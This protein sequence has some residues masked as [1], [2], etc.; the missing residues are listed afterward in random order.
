MDMDDN[1]RA[2]LRHKF[3]QVEDY[4]KHIAR[5]LRSFEKN[6]ELDRIMQ[7]TRAILRNIRSVY[8]HVKRLKLF[9][10]ERIA[11]KRAKLACQNKSPLETL[12]MICDQTMNS[13][14]IFDT[15]A[16]GTRFALPLFNHIT[17]M[18]MTEVGVCALLAIECNKIELNGKASQSYID[19]D[20]ADINATLNAIEE[21]LN[22]SRSRLEQ[23]FSVA[24]PD[25]I[26]AALEES[27]NQMLIGQEVV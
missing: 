11:H 18:I 12:D 13:A 10:D 26:H 5:E 25:A 8:K 23:E 16:E 19:H 9:R 17:S 2:C 21:A 24:V 7:E 27:N 3:A 6:N 15:I 22:R 4:L 14:K 1:I 20:L